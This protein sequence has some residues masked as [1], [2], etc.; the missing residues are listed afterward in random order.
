[1][2]VWIKSDAAERGGIMVGV[3]SSYERRDGS[4]SCSHLF[5]RGLLASETLSTPKLE[6]HGL[7]S[8]AN[9]KNMVENAIQEWIKVIYVGTDSEISLSW[10]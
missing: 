10:V 8:A 9:V 5:G 4:Y 3:W 2:V 1:M 6:L 7:S